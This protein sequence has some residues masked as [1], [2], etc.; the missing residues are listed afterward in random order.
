MLWNRGG[1]VVTRLGGGR[2]SRSCH[3]HQR[4]MTKTTTATTTTTEVIVVRHGETDWN[5]QLRVQGVTDIPLNEKGLLQ[6]KA[7]AMALQSYI[8]EVQQT[9]QEDPLSNVQIYSSHLKRAS[10][11]AKA[12]AESLSNDTNKMLVQTTPALQEWNLGALEGLCK[13]EASVEFAE[14]W[15]IFSQWAHP[16][17]SWQDARQLL[18]QGTTGV[19]GATG[20]AGG[21][22]MEQVRARAV[23]FIH[24]RVE[25]GSRERLVSGG[26]KTGPPPVLIFVTHGGVLGQLLRHVLA[27]PSTFPE[28]DCWKNVDRETMDSTNDYSRPGNACI[29]RFAIDTRT[30]ST[31][32]NET[33]W[34]ITSWA[35]T[36]HLEGDLAPIGANYDHQR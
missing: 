10:D 4:M 23:G 15:R 16:M 25:E 21:E 1:T 29:S 11:T 36:S 35:D 20:G 31:T 26:E 22:S 7:S 32:H 19:A 13:E 14:D 18:S 34:R 30:A 27:G 17:V 33:V 8:T 28:E 24:E 6:A 2:R 9:Q 3:G 5:Q 12:I